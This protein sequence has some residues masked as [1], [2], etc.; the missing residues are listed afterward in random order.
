MPFDPKT[1]QPLST[2]FDPS[3]ATEE[4]SSTFRR[5]V[6]DTGI[7]LLKG[8]I[9]VP[10]AA[11][12][13]ADIVTGG[14]AGKAAE[15]LG[16]RPKEAKQILDDLY[17]P[18]QKAANQR[19]AQAE[20]FVDTAQAMLANPSTI[21]HT[22]AESAPSMLAGGAVGRGVGAL[23]K[24]P[25]WALGAVGEGAVGAG[26]A[27]ESIRQSTD[28]GLLSAKQSGAALLSGLGTGALAG[29]GGK[30]AQKL[31]ISDVDTLLAG[32]AAQASSKSL[33]RRVAEGALT[34]G[35]L[36]ELPQSMQEQAWQN[37]ALDQPLGQG[38]AK[39]G[40]AGLLAGGVMGAGG[41]VI[42]A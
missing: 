9:G 2:S 33:P 38:V 11:V 16:F 31:G 18:E 28:D 36:Q 35:A 12:G 23:T 30:A 14:Q 8:A 42:H 29:L 20:G 41:G 7:S 24:L 19:V 13:I 1:A 17:T 4:K 39:A 10:E 21:A 3:S 6:G 27:A 5:V 34:E 22:V 25:A 37:F 15:G 26:Q 40:A 32:G